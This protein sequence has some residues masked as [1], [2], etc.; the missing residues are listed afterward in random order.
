MMVSQE[1]ITDTLNKKIWQE[2]C[3]V[4][5]KHMELL[6]LPYYDF[7]GKAQVGQMMVLSA[8]A[9]RVIIIFE[10][11]FAIKFPI[12]KMKL[13]NDYSGD[14]EKSMADNNTSAFN[15]RMI[16]NTNRYSNHSMGTA[17]DINPVQNPYITKEK[18]GSI[19]IL[20]EE[21]NCYLDRD[22][23][24]KGM[25]TQEV[26]KIFAGQGFTWGGDWET[27]K[28]YQHFELDKKLQQTLL[29]DIN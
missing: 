28:D 25:I 1:I 3:P 12:E 21:G 16:R 7:N 20:P 17:I 9:E 29:N 5:I 10:D 26:V 23:L 8:I 24:Q 22:N 19:I 27:L 4:H 18:D 2:G 14:D 11:L 15:C 13:I 6:E